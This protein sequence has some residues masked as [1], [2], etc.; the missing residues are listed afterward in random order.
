MKTPFWKKELSFSR[1]PKAPKPERA[2]KSSTPFWK[3]ELGRKKAAAPDE[4]AVDAP[5]ETLPAVAGA[6]FWKKQLSFSKP[7]LSRPSGKGGH[8][9]KKLVGLKIGSSQIAAARVSNNGVAEV[10]QLA[11]EALAPG[12]VVG[13]EL[14]DPEALGEALKGFFARNKLP[15][16]GVRLGIASNRIGVRIFDI[17]GVTEEKQ[18]ANAIHFRVD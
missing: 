13:G 18:L 8:N 16:K 6:P 10:Q 2:P 7:S 9:A 3:K 4:I 1:T 11:R 5:T 14:R 17:V 12:V 15:K